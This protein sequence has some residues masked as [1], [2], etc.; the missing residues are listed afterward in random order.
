MRAASLD[1]IFG[2]GF[3]Y[4]G[5]EKSYSTFRLFVKAFSKKLFECLSSG[6]CSLLSLSLFGFN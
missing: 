2:F 1:S 6:A 5:E 4:F 3:R